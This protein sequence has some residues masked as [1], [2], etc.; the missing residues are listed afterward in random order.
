MSVRKF[1][2]E[3]NQIVARLR[4]DN[5]ADVSDIV[6]TLL[7]KFEAEVAKRRKD[8]LAHFML[9]LFNFDAEGCLRNLTKAIALNPE[10]YV[11]T[12]KERTRLF[13]CLWFVVKQHYTD[14]DYA[15]VINEISRIYTSRI[16]E[17][18]E[19]QKLPFI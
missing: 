12:D 6:D 4:A 17:E 9:I 10:D 13:I 18:S 15:D 19:E 5:T 3:V 8:L 16:E 11:P 14:E 2:A 7:E 1:E